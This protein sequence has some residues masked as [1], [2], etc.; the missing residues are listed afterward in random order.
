MDTVREER[1]ERFATRVEKR[2]ISEGRILMVLDRM[3]KMDGRKSRFEERGVR[4]YLAPVQKNASKV[5]I[6]VVFVAGAVYIL[7]PRPASSF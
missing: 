7:L 5:C 2:R 4:G 1:G 6:S 3:R